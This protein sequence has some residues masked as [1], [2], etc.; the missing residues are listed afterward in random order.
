MEKQFCYHPADET[1]FDKSGF[2]SKNHF[3]D[4][5]RV[6]KLELAYCEIWSL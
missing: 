1:N 4:D 3:E 2:C 5:W 6:L